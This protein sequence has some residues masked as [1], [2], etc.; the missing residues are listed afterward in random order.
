MKKYDAVRWGQVDGERYALAWLGQN[1]TGDKLP[2]RSEIEW[3][4]AT[5]VGKNATESAAHSQAMERRVELHKRERAWYVD[6]FMA[7][8]KKTLMKAYTESESESPRAS[9]NHE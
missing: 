9:P 4:V 3:K 1:M 2:P 5:G 6:A 7:E 8:A